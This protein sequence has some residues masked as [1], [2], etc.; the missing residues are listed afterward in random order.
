MYKNEFLA[1]INTTQ[2]WGLAPSFD[3]FRDTTPLDPAAIYAVIQSAIEHL[4]ANEVSQECFSVT[5]LIKDKLEAL[6]KEPLYYTLGYVRLGGKPTF[7]SSLNVLKGYLEQEGGYRRGVL[8][9]AWLTTSS[10][11]IID[12][13]L[14]TTMAVI[15]KNPDWEGR[16]IIGH[17][18][19]HPSLSYHPQIVGLEYLSACGFLV[20]TDIDVVMISEK[21][22]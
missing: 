9:H 4:S 3:G 12:A 8:L 10:G 2:Q 5:L 16:C 1:A 22:Q 13:S 15:E 17:Y 18:D 14:L 20:D 6:L 11:A 7:Y 21:G 19:A